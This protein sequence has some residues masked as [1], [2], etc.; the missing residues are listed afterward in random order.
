M[1]R[2]GPIQPTTSWSLRFGL[3]LA[4]AVALALGIAFLGSLELVQSYHEAGTLGEEM[5]QNLVHVLAEQTE[6]TFQAV[7]FTLIGMRD[8]LTMHQDTSENDP[9]FRQ[10]LKEARGSV[11]RSGPVRDRAGR[12]HHS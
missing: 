8:A 11:V 1:R 9:A 6:R 4:P 3:S 7:H 12:L 2:L 10:A 5:A